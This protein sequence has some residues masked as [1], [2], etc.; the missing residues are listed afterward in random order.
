MKCIFILGL[1]LLF[2]CSS[3]KSSQTEES[4]AVVEEIQI[5]DEFLFFYDRFHVDT[6]YQLDRIIF[7]LSGKPASGK[8][9]MEL[10]DF[11][12]TRDGW[13]LHKAFK[14]DD[15]T[16]ER[17]FVVHTPDL[18]SEFIYNQ[19][20]GFYMERRFGKLS[21]GWHLIY[22]ADMQQREG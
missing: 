6:N 4:E 17:K 12:W 22:Y 8:F 19:Q 1:L 9:D 3:D 7:P 15:D 14:E 18:I 10:S 2:S 20:Y 11:K 5:P 13:V 21:D 16:F